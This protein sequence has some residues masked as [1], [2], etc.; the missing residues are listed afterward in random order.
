MAKEPTNP[1]VIIVEIVAVL[2]L[3]GVITYFG[4]SWWKDHKEKKESEGAGELGNKTEPQKDSDMLSKNK[5]EKDKQIALAKK[6]DVIKIGNMIYDAKQTFGDDDEE[7]VYSAFSLIPNLFALSLF[8]DYWQKAY[9]EDL[10]TFLRSFMND[11]ELNKINNIV[12][13]LK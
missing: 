11:E 6:M 13:K 10:F 1:Y 8:T 4:Y 5:A 7:A 3:V 12:K 2:A 9:K